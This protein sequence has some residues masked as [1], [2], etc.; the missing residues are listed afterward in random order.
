MIYKALIIAVLVAILI[1]LFSGAFF[2]AKDDHGR[3]RVVASLTF[4][5][6]LSIALIALLL[7]G[8]MTGQIQPHGL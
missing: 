7:V 2:L 8:F 4:R 5:V 3:N 1:S 6:S